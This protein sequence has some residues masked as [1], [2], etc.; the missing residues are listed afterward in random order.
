MIGRPDFIFR[1]YRLVVFVD[2]CFWHGCP[3]HATEPVTNRDFWRRKLLRN[4]QRDRQVNRRL[5]KDGWT[6]L[7]IWQHELRRRTESQ[8]VA[9][10]WAAMVNHADSSTSSARLRCRVDRNYR[11]NR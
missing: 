3:K 10:L 2:G 4:R 5:R 6:I 9:R 7:R 11:R 8:C 1:K